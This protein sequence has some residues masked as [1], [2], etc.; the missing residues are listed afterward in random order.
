MDPNSALILLSNTSNISRNLAISSDNEDDNVQGGIAMARNL[1]DFRNG[2]NWESEPNREDVTIL[3]TFE[4]KFFQVFLKYS[5]YISQQSIQTT[6]H[7]MAI[8]LENLIPFCC[9]ARENNTRISWIKKALDEHADLRPEVRNGLSMI[10]IYSFGTAKASSIEGLDMFTALQDADDGLGIVN[11]TSLK[12][13]NDPI[14]CYG[15]LKSCMSGLI[16][17]GKIPENERT[18]QV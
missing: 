7:L 4:P 11:K 1:L 17:A 8:C 16:D 5:Q 2:S 6:G 3:K 9:W 15:F 18:N 13:Y 12:I 14:F 10:L